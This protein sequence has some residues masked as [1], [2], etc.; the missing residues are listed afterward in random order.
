MDY[1]QVILALIIGFFIGRYYKV[2]V[3]IIQMFN[4]KDNKV[5]KEDLYF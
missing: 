2:I 1:F 4:R 5:N 3:K